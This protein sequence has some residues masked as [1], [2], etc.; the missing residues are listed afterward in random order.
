MRVT[1]GRD[2][3]KEITRKTCIRP[4]DNVFDSV[5]T[6]YMQRERQKGSKGWRGGKFRRELA[7]CRETRWQG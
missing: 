6:R 1:T 4:K 7:G 5:T 2:T 3:F